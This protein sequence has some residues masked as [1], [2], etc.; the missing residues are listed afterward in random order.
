MS[1]QAVAAALPSDVSSF[2]GRAQE[3]EEVKELLSRSRLL[4][5][6]GPGGCGKTRLALS[7]ARELAGDFHDDV[8]WVE[9]AQL[10]AP[11]LVPRAV[12]G[13]LG[14]REAPGISSTQA[15]AEHIGDTQLLLVLDN[16]EHLIE[17]CAGLS[18]ALMVGCPNLKILATSR[19]AMNVAGEVAWLVPSLSVPNIGYQIEELE[20][21]ESVRLFVERARA[22][23][24]RF[25]LDVENAPAVIRI[26]QRLDGIP[27]AIELAAAR[28]KVL[29]ASDIAE[30]LDDCFRLLTGG[31]RVAL[32]RQ[33][34]LGGTMDWGYDLLSADEKDLFRRLAVFAGGFTL[35]AAEEVC[36]GEGIAGG[37]VLDL[38]SS[39]VKKSL[40]RMAVRGEQA[41][42][43]M[44]QTVLQYAAERLAE[45]GDEDAVRLR[46]AEYYLRLAEHAE[47]ELSGDAQTEWMDTLDTE[48]GNLRT[49]MARLLQASTPEP[50]L[51]L[52]SA[53]WNFCHARGHYA[54][55]RAWLEA[56]V[57][58]SGGPPSLR[59]RALT[60]AGVLAFLQCE[61]GQ[62]REHLEGAL[63]LYR[64]LEERR[65]IAEVTEVLGGVAR[66]EGD[67]ERA[68]AL[69]EEGLALWRDLG[70]E[71]GVAGALDYLGFVAWLKGDYGRATEL[72][73]KALSM[74]RYAGDNRGVLSALI[75]LGSAVLYAGDLGRAE[76]LLKESLALSKEG[77]Y[78]EG[79]GWTLNQLG[80]LAHRQADHARADS[81][82]RESLE[83][84]RDLGDLWRVASVLEALAETAAVGGKFERAARLFGGAEALREDTGTPLPPCERPDHER[85]VAAARA[86]MGSDGFAIE[87]AR[88]RAAPLDATLARAVEP[89]ELVAPAATH[90]GG[91]S[92]REVEVLGLVAQGLTDAEVA[93]KLYLSPRTV[94]SHLRAVYRKLEVPSRAAA[95]KAAIE[96]RLI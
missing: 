55:G 82:L 65:G 20:R 72:C 46:H 43:R 6:T 13:A 58:K 60:G 86:E 49:A 40:V 14:D 30:R 78:R 85:G 15:I 35:E 24:P 44:L 76:S 2:V 81:L 19:E 26:C 51:R 95:V 39:L 88:G 59:A 36:S 69:H 5:L 11:D 31:S 62:S 45:S 28:T 75:N 67:Y 17:A 25:E 91:L 3:L 37:E 57:A 74:N 42:Y 71:K 8:Y 48:M 89:E 10:S 94:N 33:R 52:A 18:H 80:V 7:V 16:C 47:T 23:S 54:E 92:E 27:L 56:A 41:R 68:E 79:I 12:L 64:D 53:L 63:S 73:A 61:Y 21:Y 66:E 70:D 1:V 38:L 9:L 83:V 4:T 22:A 90:A 96:R 50:S 87:Q 93:D 32:P 29:A 84:Q 34:T 77:G